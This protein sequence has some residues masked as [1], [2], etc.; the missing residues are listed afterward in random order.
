MEVA[1]LADKQVQVDLAVVAVQPDQVDQ[2]ADP[3]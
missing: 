3:K 1:V 2:A